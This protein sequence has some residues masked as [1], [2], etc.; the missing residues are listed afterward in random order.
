M[1]RK[2]ETNAI[3]GAYTPEQ[4][5]KAAAVPVYRTAAYTFRDTDHAAGLFSLEEKGHIYSRISNPTCEVLENRMALLEGGKGA[6]VLASGTSAVFYSV[7]NLCRSGDEIIA[8]RNLYG[9]TFTMF[10]NILPQFGITARLVDINDQESVAAAVSE[11]TRLIYCETLGNPTLEAADIEETAKTAHRAGLPLIVDSTFTPPCMFRPVDYGA[12]IVIHSM[13]K[14]LGGH[15]TAIGGVVVDSGGF[16]WDSARFPL[17]SEPDE[18]Y[19]GIVWGRD[20]GESNDIAFLVRMRTVPLRNL[21]ACISPDNAWL[22]LQ[23]LE[24][25]SLRMERH[26]SNAMETARFLKSHPNVAWVRY[27]GLPD[28]PSHPAAS[29]YFR[30]GFGGMVVFGIKGGKKAGEGFI[31]RLELFSHLANVGD[32]KSL[33]IHPASTTHAQLTEAQQKQAGIGPDLIRLSVGLEH[34]DDILADLKNVLEK[35]D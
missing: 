23:S 35:V 3:H 16:S 20:L 2:F 22:F 14:W 13:T 34:I 29:R 6:L 28:D 19:H 4:E 11:K 15:G 18:S 10:N 30:G 32:A 7:I 31:N 24:T 33:A 8:S 1:N 25:L 21:G 26:N 5:T 27:P 17:F 12:D 9:G